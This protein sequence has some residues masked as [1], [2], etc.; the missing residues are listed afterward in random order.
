MEIPAGRG[1]RVVA[2]GEELVLWRTGD[3]VVAAL[4]QCPHQHFSVLHQGPVHDGVV[5]CPMHGWSFV[6]ATGCATHGSG[7]LH[8]LPVRVEGGR[9]KVELHDGQAEN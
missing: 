6:I 8:L 9:V 4:N 5:T 1:K 3:S 2:G 7:R